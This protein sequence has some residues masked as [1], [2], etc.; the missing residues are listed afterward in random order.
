MSYT[1]TIV[2]SQFLVTRVCVCVCVCVCACM[3][4]CARMCLCVLPDCPLVFSSSS[5]R[6]GFLPIDEE[7]PPQ[8]RGVQNGGVPELHGVSSLSSSL[9][10][11][12][13][14]RSQDGLPRPPSVSSISQGP[15][16]GAN[17]RDILK[18]L[19]SPPG[20]GGAETLCYPDPN[21]LTHA[22]LPRLFHSFDR[23]VLPDVLSW[24]RGG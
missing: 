24:S 10:G 2:D 5:S 14:G 11:G 20:E 8:V 9:E 19:V 15:R 6:S 3:R 12:R 1:P 22:A 23:W 18:S 21:T 7:S 13:R 16:G 4:V 17:V